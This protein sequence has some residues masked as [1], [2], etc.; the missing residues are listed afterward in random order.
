M[1]RTYVPYAGFAVIVIV[2][3][4]VLKNLGPRELKT[5]FSLN[6]P[7]TYAGKQTLEIAN[8]GEGENWK[9]NYT[10]DSVRTFDDE[11]GMNIF[12]TQEVP[13]S[14]SRV[15]RLD[16]SGYDTLF[17]YVLAPDAQTASHIARLSIGF[18]NAKDETSFK[19]TNLKEGWNYLVLAKKDFSSKNFDWKTTESAFVELVSKKG[20]TAQIALDRLWAQNSQMDNDAFLT[21]DKRYLNL[22]TLNKETYLNL[23]SPIE[24][25]VLFDKEI[26]RDNFSYTVALAPLKP[27]SFGL[28]FGMDKSM[29]NGFR[30]TLAGNR[31]NS[32]V[33]EKLEENGHKVLSRGEIKNTLMEKEAL[34]FMRVEQRGSK[35]TVGAS[36]DNQEYQPITQ[37]DDAVFSPG[38]AGIQYNGSYLIESVEVKE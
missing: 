7:D 15:R 8:F 34:L 17:A 26:K 5:S 14:I 35:L 10:F 11:V 28:M 1:K 3:F 4:F 6:F 32:F 36:Y 31:M 20:T 33:L 37:T 12:S 27:G 29:K 9:G 38:Y 16:L 24:A 19:V 22:K 18:R 21:Y 23:A 13:A 30:F 25:S 2:L